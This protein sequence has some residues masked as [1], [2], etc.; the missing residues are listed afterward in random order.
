MYRR[1]AHNKPQP[2]NITVKYAGVC[3]C[4]GAA[5]PAGS[6]ATYYPAG[7][8]SGNMSGIAHIGGLEG[9]SSRCSGEIANRR[10]DNMDSYV[11]EGLG[12]NIDFCPSDN[13]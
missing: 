8:L 1:Y 3:L 12:E 4:C 7:T 10:N 2:R 9:N 11:S 5:I 13:T 6:I